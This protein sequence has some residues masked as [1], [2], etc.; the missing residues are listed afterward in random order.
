MIKNYTCISVA[1]FNCSDQHVAD[2]IKLL[3]FNA[4]LTSRSEYRKEVRFL[5]VLQ[6]RCVC[7]QYY[8]QVIFT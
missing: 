7:T 1:F 4:W 3:R 6:N 8:H 2:E 5:F